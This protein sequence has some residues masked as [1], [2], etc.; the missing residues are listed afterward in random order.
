MWGID[1][2]SGVSYTISFVLVFVM[3]TL[4][5]IIIG[6]LMP[7]SIAIRYSLESSL[8]I[9]LPLRVIYVIVR[10]LTWLIGKIS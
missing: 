6:E 8:I 10:P 2:S 1:V 4:F 3:I 5:Q 9:A 7:K